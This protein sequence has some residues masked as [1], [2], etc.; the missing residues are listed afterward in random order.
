ME[1]AIMPAQLRCWQHESVG[2]EFWQPG[3]YLRLLYRKL[4]QGAIVVL[5][6]DDARG[7]HF[8]Q[9]NFLGLPLSFSVGPFRVA[10]RARVSL[11]HVFIIRDAGGHHRFFL[12]VPLVARCGACQPLAGRPSI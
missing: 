7:G 1:R 5:Y 10:A 6:G 12:Q 4:Q 11:I 2:F 9:V 3:I 8:T